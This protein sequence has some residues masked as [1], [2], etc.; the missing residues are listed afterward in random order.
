MIGSKAP[1]SAMMKNANDIAKMNMKNSAMTSAAALSEK[2]LFAANKGNNNSKIQSISK[3]L[4]TSF[5]EIK[6]EKNLYEGNQ[7]DNGMN[8]AGP[9]P[10]PLPRKSSILRRWVQ[11]VNVWAAISCVT[12]FLIFTDLW[13][14]AWHW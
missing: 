14:Q 8:K 7:A 10:P 11:R 1:D 9:T 2:Q 12:Q 3:N 4:Y 13:T 6:T 5:C